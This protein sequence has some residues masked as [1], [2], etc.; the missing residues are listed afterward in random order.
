MK[1]G[2]PLAEAAYLLSLDH[3]EASV[4]ESSEVTVGRMYQALVVV[5][6]GHLIRAD[7]DYAMRAVPAGREYLVWIIEDEEGHI[8]EHKRA[9]VDSAIKTAKSM[10]EDFAGVTAHYAKP[11]DWQAISDGFASVR[12]EEGE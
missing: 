7:L 9:D 12:S 8:T 4:G 5:S 11:I 3:A 6:R 2:T 10:R 1:Y